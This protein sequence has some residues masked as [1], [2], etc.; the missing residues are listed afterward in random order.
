MT[1]PLKILHVETGMHLYGG[2]LQVNY[3]LAGL[4]RGGGTENVLVC[5]A[6]SRIGREAESVANRVYAVPMRGDLDFPFILRLVR[7]I[8][9]ERP[10]IVHL[11][12]RRGADVLGGIA[13][14]L[15][16][17]RCIL[18]RRVDN[19]ERRLLAKLKYRLYDR[20]ITISDGIKTV[21]CGEGV[22]AEKISCVR[23]AVDVEK[24]SRQCDRKWFLK[25]FGLP[26]DAVVCATVAQ[27]IQR[28]GHRYLIEA[29]PEILRSHSNARFIF[30]GKGPLED[31]LKLQCRE[32]GISDYVI[33]AGF[34]DDLERVL[35]CLDLVIHPALMEGLGIEPGS[36]GGITAAVVRLLNKPDSAQAMGQ[37]GK[38]VARENFSVEEMVKG[39]L[40]VY[41]NMQK[42]QSEG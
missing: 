21:L 5:P 39:N 29:I 12:S 4:K 9:T 15:T 13:A 28:K 24:F 22:P 19:P 35:P 36:T 3:L 26:D 38:E 1:G 2:A 23:S 10:D 16:G 6:G 34:R 40:E 11:H 27:L 18:T 41:L 20:I 30:L 25:E 42:I 14:K 37:Q 32:S 31:E 17:T 8:R 33:F 7:I